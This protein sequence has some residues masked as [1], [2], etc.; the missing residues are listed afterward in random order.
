[1][2]R[3][4]HTPLAQTSFATLR[5]L[6]S[7]LP[8]GLQ[9]SINEASLVKIYEDYMKT[10]NLQKFDFEYMEKNNSVNLQRNENKRCCGII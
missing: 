3:T 4:T 7:Y 1:M 8:E 5:E 9:P 10:N 6:S 2:E